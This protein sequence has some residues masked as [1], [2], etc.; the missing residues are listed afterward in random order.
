M[1][2]IEERIKL[3][4]AE[5]ILSE[6]PL[7]QELAD[8]TEASRKDIRDII[9]G[10]SERKIMIVG[11][12][13][14]SPSE[15]VLEFAEKI[16]PIARSVREKVVMVLRVYIQKPR[17]TVGWPGPLVQ[18]DPYSAPDMPKGIRLCRKM[19]LDVLK[20]GLPLADEMLFTHNSGYFDDLLSYLAV[21]ARSAEDSE[22]RYQAS[23]LSIP[24]GIKNPTS[25]NSGIGVNS[26]IAAQS[27]HTFPHAGYQVTSRGNPYAHLILRGGIANNGETET[28]YSTEKMEDALS[29]MGNKVK[30][31]AIIVD[32]SHDNCRDPKTGKKDH[33]KQ[34]DVV[35]STL[36]SMERSEPVAR[37]LKGWMVESFLV[38][39]SQDATKVKREDLTYGMS[40]T[41][42]C[43]SLAQFEDI[44]GATYERLSK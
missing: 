28:N 26:L 31:P 5:Q 34:L 20:I 43:I 32:A 30:N 18:P 11:P 36:D 13:S 14:A 2:N 16:M 17:T 44:M 4:S 10:R 8:K 12:C 38:E 42:P 6:L 22:H 29:K 25:G 23:S 41:D 19:N 33:R 15:A 21:G 35:A 27:G 40:I 7:S 1:E 24:I 3:P 9:A 39:G 37:N